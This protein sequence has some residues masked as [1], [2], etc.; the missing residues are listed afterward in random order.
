MPTY[1][2]IYEDGK[3]EWVNE[4]P[5]PGRYR[6]LVTV[7]EE[8]TSSPSEEEVQ[9]VLDEADGAWGTGKTVEEIDEDV[10]EL[11]GEWDRPWYDADRS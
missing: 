8:G 1:E 10:E 11:R 2:A 6:V 5:D 9:R 4:G 7:T 3:L